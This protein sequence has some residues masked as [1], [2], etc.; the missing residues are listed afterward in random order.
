MCTL[1]EKRKRDTITSLYRIL[2]LQLLQ[3]RLSDT[4]KQMCKSSAKLTVKARIVNITQ[5]WRC[6]KSFHFCDFMYTGASD[7]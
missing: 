7:L 3:Q 1:L 2:K 5:C 6:L 4:H